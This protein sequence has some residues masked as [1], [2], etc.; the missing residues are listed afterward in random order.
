[1]EHKDKPDVTWNIGVYW[2]HILWESY[3]F[4]LGIVF[5]TF[6]MEVKEKVRKIEE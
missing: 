2:P 4:T 5:A 6:H 1:M 3:V